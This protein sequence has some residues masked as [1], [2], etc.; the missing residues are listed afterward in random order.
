VKLTKLGTVGGK[1]VQMRAFLTFDSGSTGMRLQAA[2]LDG[3]DGFNVC[4]GGFELVSSGALLV[5]DLGG[6]TKQSDLT[7]F[8]LVPDGGDAL[9]LTKAQATLK[10]KAE[11]GKLVPVALDITGPT[12][13]RVRGVIDA[14]VC[15]P[16]KS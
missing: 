9:K 6:R 10:A 16:P 1:T 3:M 13:T 11:P 14:I 4:P 2:E 12:G 5:I 7:R 8:K 15:F